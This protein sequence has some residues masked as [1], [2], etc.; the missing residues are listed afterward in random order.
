MLKQ[1]NAILVDFSNGN[2]WEFLKTMNE[3]TERTWEVIQCISN[4]DRIG[5]AANLKRYM[6]YF[7]FPFKI[8]LHRKSFSYIIAWQQ[9]Y[10]LIFTFYCQVFHVRKFSKLI[11]MAF[12]YKPKPGL[13]GRIYHKFMNY[14]VHSKYIDKIICF[15]SHEC[16][17]Y[18]SLFKVEGSKFEFVQLGEVLQNPNPSDKGN[19]QAVGEYILSAGYSN[20]DFDFLIDVLKDTD[21][22]VKIYGDKNIDLYDNIRVS[23]ENLESKNWE[24]ISGCRCLA[25]PLKEPNISAGHL[26]IIHAMQI[27]KP[28]IVTDSK[29]IQDLITHGENGFIAPN[30]K[31]IWLDYISRIYHDEDLYNTMCQKAKIRYTNNHTVQAMGNAIGNLI[32]SIQ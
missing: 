27:G 14:I 11:V 13:A 6:K 1:S 12:I 23:N 24:I 18:T 25:I 17:Y 10:G 30:D 4:K 16:I 32:M 7:I 15:S 19:G 2:D 3:T 29:G 31:H 21:Y 9:F 26:T 5:L 28:V 20:R 8:F 22:Q